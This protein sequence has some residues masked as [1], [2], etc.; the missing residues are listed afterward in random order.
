MENVARGLFGRWLFRSWMLRKKLFETRRPALTTFLSWVVL[1]G[2]LLVVAEGILIGW[3]LAHLVP[4]EW[5]LGV[6]EVAPWYKT[7]QLVAALCLIITGAAGVI[8]GF[9]LRNRRAFGAYLSVILYLISLATGAVL[10]YAGTGYVAP[11]LATL[12]GVDIALGIAI[13]SL[14]ALS[15]YTLDPLGLHW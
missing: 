11:V 4:A 14:L 10:L 6:F 13:P 15:W 8:A 1:A 7:P 9:G 3:F 5:T 2:G 12:G